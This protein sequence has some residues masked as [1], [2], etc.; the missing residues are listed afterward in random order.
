MLDVEPGD[1]TP[2]EAPAWFDRRPGNR[3]I[4][5]MASMANQVKAVMGGRDYLLW[6]AHY[7][8]VPHICGPGACA[9]PQADATQWSDKGPRGENV[10]QSVLSEKFYT[11]ITQPQGEEDMPS[12]QEIAAAVWQQV[13]PERSGVGPARAEDF[14]LDTRIL[15]ESAAKKNVWDT[16]LQRAT[17]DGS[18]MG[19]AQAED[20]ITDTRI[21]LD[22]VIK[23]L[24]AIEAELKK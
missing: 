22:G 9:Y 19:P 1:A 21:L 17:S 7:N 3:I 18:V 5:C 6:S 14:L 10:D 2:E 20:W 23:R 16:Q 11:E 13:I 4:Y 12:S 24:D 15:A 8:G